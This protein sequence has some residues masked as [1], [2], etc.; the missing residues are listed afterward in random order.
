M[1]KTCVMPDPSKF[2]PIGTLCPLFE[3]QV[4]M[5]RPPYLLLDLPR[6]YGPGQRTSLHYCL[7]KT[8]AKNRDIL[9]T[10]NVHTK[11]RNVPRYDG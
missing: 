4:H 5:V 2:K 9:L 3:A 6:C 11:Y 8:N 1:G 7:C 10:G